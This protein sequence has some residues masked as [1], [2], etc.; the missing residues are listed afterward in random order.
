MKNK[1]LVA[2]Q[3][4]AGDRES[5][6][7][8]LDIFSR[9]I[10]P[11]NPWADLVLYPRFDS[12]LPD[13]TVLRK[14]RKVF[15]VVWPLKSHTQ[16]TGWPN[17]CNYLW[18]DLVMETFRRSTESNGGE[19]QWAKYKGVLAIE[20]DT[21]P[22]SDDWLE[23]IS[24]EWDEHR[25]NFMGAWDD[26]NQDHDSRL[27]RVGHINGNAMFAMDLAKK[28]PTVLG[29]PLNKGWDTY[30]APTFRKIGW[31]GTF[32]IQNFYDTKRL[33]EGQYDR[34]LREKCVLLHGV[35]D[36]SVRDL[37][38]KYRCKTDSSTQAI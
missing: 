6:L 37:Y 18:A 1:F 27:T 3:Y 24:N 34:L 7:G 13:E 9:T 4:W 22:L 11:N 35:K 28:A 31:A 23:V 36:K 33:T 30:H 21:C 5:A 8:L 16:M 32:A 26:R 38:L 14:L 15:E 20:S 17:G 19:P 10:K 29:T 25:V 2:L 12:Q